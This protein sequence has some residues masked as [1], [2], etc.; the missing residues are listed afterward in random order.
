MRMPASVDL[1]SMHAR[2]E[3]ASR[4]LKTLGNAQRL[5]MLCLLVRGEMS[6]SQINERLPDLSQSALSQHLARLRDEGLVRTR[7]EAQTIWYELPEGPVQS[8]IATL[9]DTYCAI[10]AADKNASRHPAKMPKQHAN[11][12]RGRRRNP[13]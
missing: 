5:R 6:V 1:T 13:K 11:A 4:L 7:R 10:D 3:E 8:I 2:A 9:Y 12:T